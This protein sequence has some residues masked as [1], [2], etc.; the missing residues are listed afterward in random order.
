MN[1]EFWNLYNE[2]NESYKNIDIEE[3]SFKNNDL[4]DKDKD[5]NKDKCI[6]CKETDYLITESE[7]IVCTFCGIE[8]KRIIDQSVEWR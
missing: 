8:N 5:K 7:M 1:T 3:G 6:N 2:I 4:K